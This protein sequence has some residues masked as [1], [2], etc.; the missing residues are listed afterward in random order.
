MLNI[1]VKN[2]VDIENGKAQHNGRL[3]NLLNNRLLNVHKGKDKKKE[4]EKKIK[5]R[6]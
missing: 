4:K 2:I 5:D 3:M 1:P 6:L